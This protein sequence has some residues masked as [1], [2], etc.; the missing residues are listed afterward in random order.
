MPEGLT[1]TVKVTKTLSNGGGSV[2]WLTNDQSEGE[3]TVPILDSDRD[4]RAVY[5]QE[6]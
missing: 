2:S 3:E 6:A 5:E 4:S 1:S